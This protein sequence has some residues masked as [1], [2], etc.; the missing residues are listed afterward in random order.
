[1]SAEL[2]AA[3]AWIRLLGTHGTVAAAANAAN[4]E[5]EARKRGFTDVVVFVQR[6]AAWP[7]SAAGDYYVRA[8]A[9]KAQT[10]DRHTSVFLGSVD[11]IDAW[12]G[13]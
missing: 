1:M 2:A 6:P 12:Q 9:G 7:S 13:S 10:V 3:W 4:V 11:V 8:V 5:A